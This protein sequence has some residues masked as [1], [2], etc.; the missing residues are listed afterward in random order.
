MMDLWLTSSSHFLSLS[1]DRALP[2]S[3]ALAYINPHYRTLH[4]HSSAPSPPPKELHE[5]IHPR[6]PP[7]SGVSISE[8]ADS[9]LITT[10]AL[11]RSPEVFVCAFQ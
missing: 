7:K 9:Q 4:T 8:G 2:P 3:S 11:F 1:F 10:Q 5:A 6:L